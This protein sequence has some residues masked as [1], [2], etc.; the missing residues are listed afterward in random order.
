[1]Q[2]DPAVRILLGTIVVCLAILIV[3]GFA[4]PRARGSQDPTGRYSVTG[5]RA[6]GPMLVRADTATGRVWKLDL[7]GEPGTWVE[8]REPDSASAP[9]AALDQGDQER[10]DPLRGDRPL[11]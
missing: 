10:S 7:R 5:V 4:G 8:F 3:Q 6:G 2:P 11:Q 1:M 9:G